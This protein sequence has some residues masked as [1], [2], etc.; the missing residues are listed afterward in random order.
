MGDDLQGCLLKPSEIVRAEASDD[1]QK[2][3]QELQNKL[4]EQLKKLAELQAKILSDFDPI[5]C[6]ATGVTTVSFPVRGHCC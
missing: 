5:G 1:N 6:R 2:M 4:E 3:V